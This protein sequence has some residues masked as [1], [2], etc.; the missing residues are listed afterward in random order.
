L[1]SS[2][3]QQ[4]VVI[5]LNLFV[6]VIMYYYYYAT[7]GG[8]RFWVRSLNFSVRFQPRLCPAQW[9]KYLTTLQI[10]QF[11]IDLFVV[12]FASTSLFLARP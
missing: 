5:T 4:W 3:R 7:A 10:V 12:Y 1:T 6:H 2:V 8:R 11:I 9:K